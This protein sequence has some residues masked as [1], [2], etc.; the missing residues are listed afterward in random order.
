MA[1]AR[2][3]G[4]RVVCVTATRGERG[5]PDPVAWP[6]DR[7]AAERT[8]ELA[9]CLAS[10]GCASTTGWATATATA[11][12]LTGTR[13]SRGSVRCSTSPPGHRA[14]VRPGRHDR[15]P[16]PPDRLGV[17]RGA[18]DR[19]A[20][21]GPAAALRAGRSPGAR[22]GALNQ[23][24]GV[25]QP[26]YPVAHPGRVAGPRPGPGPGR[27]RARSG[28][29]PPSR[30]RRPGWIATLGMR[31]LRGVGRRGVVRRG[32]PGRHRDRP[33]GG[34]PTRLTFR[35]IACRATRGRPAARGRADDT[36]GRHRRGRGRP[37]RGRPQR[38]GRRGSA[39][40]SRRNRSAR[41][42]KVGHW[43]GQLPVRAK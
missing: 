8:H 23:Q 2:D 40:P 43:W 38:R 28:R 4:Q 9:R 1:L 24:L 19:A 22:W 35:S 25:Y 39:S 17:G 27:R 12:W 36:D 18:V 7:L 41:L 31:R 42:R 13:R 21:R 30:P 34:H 26:G 3:N 37:G 10:S 5:T 6:P 32:G 33:A 14:D 20:P 16:G 29:W 15:A 11:P